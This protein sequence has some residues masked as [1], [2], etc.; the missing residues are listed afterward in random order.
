MEPAARALAALRAVRIDDASPYATAE[1]RILRALGLPAGDDDARLEFWASRHP[2]SRIGDDRYRWEIS[3]R[4]VRPAAHAS[5]PSSWLGFRPDVERDPERG[6]IRLSLPLSIAEHADYL[7]GLAAST[8]PLAPKASAILS[9][10]DAIFR[11]DLAAHIAC[12]HAWGDSFAL[13]LLARRPHALERLHPLA[14][15]MAV[16]LAALVKDGALPGLQFPFHGVP[17]VSA[18]AQLA[19]GLLALGLETPVLAALV[20]ATAAAAR[21]DGTFGD[22]LPEHLVEKF[23]RPD[24]LT[25]F[26]ALDLLAHVDPEFDPEPSLRALRGALDDEGFLRAC[27]PERAWLTGELLLLE[28]SA[29]MGGGG[30]FAERFRFPAATRANLDRKT[31]LPF[32]AHFDD[33]ATLFAAIDGIA[34]AP[35]P[36]AFIDLAGFRDFN[37]RYGQD[38]GDDV[39]AAFAEELRSI[40]AARIV[41]DGGDEFLV[42][43]APTRAPLEADLDQFRRSWPDRFVARFGTD[44]PP[45]VPRIL[46][47]TGRGAEL[48]AAREALGRALGSVKLGSKV[49]PREGV[50]HSLG[51]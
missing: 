7:A 19:G 23:P 20:R 42:V 25:T 47:V 33:L 50:L 11:R 27:G 40:P 35:A 45:V 5:A 1:A 39:L 44:A 43:G 6:E 29:R 26:A 12:A 13:F 28:R 10:A 16:S 31:G 14:V 51:S 49:P 24:V 30:G 9:E 21:P 2:G 17:L 22:P 15:A 18:S 48:L 32:Y 36:L 38:R 3:H 41:R 37:N 8:G 4:R 34:R 46:V